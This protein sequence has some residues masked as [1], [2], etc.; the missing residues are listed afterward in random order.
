MLHDMIVKHY[1]LLSQQRGYA[2]R[3][4]EY[5]I[6]QFGY[7]F[8]QQSDFERSQMFFRVNMDYYPLSFNAYDGM[9]DYYLARNQKAE[10]MQYFKKA[11]KLKFSA[12][13]KAKLDKL[14]NK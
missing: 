4:P 5:M 8:L 6:N 10:A 11:L 9:G 7:I 13:I 14:E 12:E 1:Q 2:V 3:P